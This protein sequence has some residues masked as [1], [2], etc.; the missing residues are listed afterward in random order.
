M[1]LNPG[2][3]IGALLVAGLWV[4]FGAMSGKPDIVGGMAKT[5][6]LPMLVGGFVGNVAWSRLRKRGDL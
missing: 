5:V 2:G 3:I 1:N 6:W 4:G